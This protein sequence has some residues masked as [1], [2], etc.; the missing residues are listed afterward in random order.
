MEKKLRTADIIGRRL[1]DAGVRFAFGVPGGEVLTLIDGLEKAGICFVLSK[2]ENAAGFMAEGVHHMSGAPA[3][4]I[5]TVGPGAANAVNVTAN[6][7]QDRVPMIVITGCVDPVD[8]VTYNHQVFDH[9][10]VF[11]PICKASYTVPDGYVSELIDKAIAIATEGRPGPVHLD[12]P[13]AIATQLHD[14][15]LVNHRSR[16]AAVAPADGADLNLARKWLSEAKQPL[17]IAGVDAVNQNASASITR[18]AKK[19]GAPVIATYKAKGIIADDESLSLGGAGLSPLGDKNLIP[20]IEKAD[21]ILLAGYDPIEMRNG[22]R[23]VWNSKEKNVVEL[24][25]AP[26]YSYMHQ[27]SVSF[28]C[29]INEGLS[30]LSENIS[31]SATWPNNEPNKL[32]KD[33]KVAYGQ[34][35]PWGP[36]AIATVIRGI[37][38]R[39]T[40]VTM[41]SGAHRILL[42]Q[43]WDTFIPHSVLQSSALCTMGCALP[44]ATGAKLAAPNTPIIAFTGDG[45]LEMVLGELIT[46]RDLKL[47]VIIVVFV[48]ASLALI[49]KKQREMN[50]ANVGVDM[51]ETN[52]ASIAD[53]LGGKGVTVD[54]R[55][56]LTNAIND[57]L[58]SKVYTIVS[59]KIPRGSYDG[60]I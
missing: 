47:P 43:V 59:C 57:A 41:D 24:L 46:L 17:I 37:M 32:K 49:E 15:E 22:W 18:F 52:F 26:E 25:V 53:V 36:A 31:N 2:H 51:H 14:V 1:Y 5:A 30:A 20:L 56:S 39:N 40:V 34:D 55:I 60:K 58:S 13:I 16:P 7:Q 33:N 29:N 10:A 48:D 19:F 54:D 6:A 28:I 45:G 50:Y 4:L 38:P 3:V 42:S 9:R 35:E 12:L 21:F 8:T 44:L 23:N 11:S 27:A